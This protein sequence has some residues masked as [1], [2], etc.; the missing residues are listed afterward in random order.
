MIKKLVFHNNL[1]PDS[2]GNNEF[3]PLEIRVDVD[4]DG[5][6][7]LHNHLLIDTVLQVMAQLNKH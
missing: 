6:I 2:N 5:L 3:I 7:L 1:I 4:H